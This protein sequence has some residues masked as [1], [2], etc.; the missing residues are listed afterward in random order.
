MPFDPKVNYFR[1]FYKLYLENENLMTD[2]DLTSGDNHKTER[3][4]LNI[5]DF[6]DCTLIPSIATQPQ[7]FVHRKQMQKF[8]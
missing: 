1:E 4:I 8:Q 2:I 7:K 3:R 6:Y 5:V